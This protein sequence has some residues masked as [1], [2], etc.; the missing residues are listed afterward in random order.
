MY[1][2]NMIGKDM[3][4]RKCSNEL[5]NQFSSG[6]NLCDEVGLHE[7]CRQF[8]CILKDLGGQPQRV[9]IELEKAWG[10]IDEAFLISASFDDITLQQGYLLIHSY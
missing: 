2:S 3:N 5:L 4:S 9:A 1:S 10:N 6:I 8:I 7:Y